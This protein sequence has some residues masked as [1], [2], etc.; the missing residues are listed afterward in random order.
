MIFDYVLPY[1]LAL[2]SHHLSLRWVMY[3]PNWSI[4]LCIALFLCVIYWVPW[5]WTGMLLPKCADFFWLNCC[6]SNYYSLSIILLII[7]SIKWKIFTSQHQDQK[8]QGNNILHFSFHSSMHSNIYRSTASPP[9][10]AGLKSLQRWACFCCYLTVI[11]S[12]ALSRQ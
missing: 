8:S 3:A 10:K 1:Q 6:R 9:T 12:R 11:Q 4:I 2:W 7:L 5:Q